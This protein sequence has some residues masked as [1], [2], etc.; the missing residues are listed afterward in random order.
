MPKD[1]Q[2]SSSLQNTQQAPGLGSAKPNSSK[3]SESD[4]AMYLGMMSLLEA[5]GTTES[6]GASMAE[7]STTLYDT[8]VKNGMNNIQELQAELSSLGFLQAN[9]S[10]FQSYANWSDQL[11]SAHSIVNDPHADPIQKSMAESMIK[12]LSGHAPP[13]PECSAADIKSYVALVNQYQSLTGFRTYINSVSQQIT[14]A[15]NDVQNSKQL[16]DSLQEQVNNFVNDQ[17]QESAIEASLLRLIKD[18]LRYS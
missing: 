4:H 7:L 11:S 6:L 18:Q 1:I 17:G 16:P 9:W 5:M 8:L 3:A 2:N 12:A 15:N 13:I 10:Q 14:V